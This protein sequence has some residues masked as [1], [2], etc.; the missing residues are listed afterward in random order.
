MGQIKRAFIFPFAA[1]MSCDIILCI[2]FLIILFH[3]DGGIML[4][5]SYIYRTFTRLLSVTLLI[6]FCF[7]FAGCEQTQTNTDEQEPVSVSDFKLNTVVDIKIYDSRDRSL[8]DDCLSLCDRYELVFSRTNE[9]SELYRLN[10]REDQGQESGSFPYK[11]STDPDSQK[12]TWMI[13]PQLADLLDEGL[14]FTKES[15]GAFDI[16]IAPLTSLWDFTAE[17]PQV[18]ADNDIQT[19]LP[20]CSSDGVELNGQKLTLPS[21]DTAFDVGA[22]AKGY[23]ADRISEYL[24]KSGVKSAII[25]LGGNV[26]CI[27]GRPDGEPFKVG[28]QKPFA[29]R[30]ETAAV[31]DINGRSVVSS[32]IYERCFKQ[33]GKL[34]H[35]I[36]DPHTGYPYDNGL[37]SVTIISDRSVDGDALSTTCF[38]LGL[39]KG[40]TFAEKKGVQAVFIT[41]DYELHYTKDFQ[42]K[43]KVSQVD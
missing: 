29:D 21:P 42:K 19:A 36:L 30:N 37:I 43:I 15:G 39:K 34:Y 35:H 4:K 23:I 25:N 5:K 3:S 9:D 27:G 11:I 6:S 32:G 40:L 31:V 18:P 2:Y 41:K 10:H 17:D 26:L 12:E 33:D 8:L 20:L 22:I 16:A 24:K 38:A 1:T 14:A 13:S 28:V 7:L